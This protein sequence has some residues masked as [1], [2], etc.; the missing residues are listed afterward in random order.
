MPLLV[1]CVKLGRARDDKPKSGLYVR[2]VFGPTYYTRTSGTDGRV[3]F[4]DLPKCL[5]TD[6]PELYVN[7]VKCSGVYWRNRGN[8]TRHARVRVYRTSSPPVEI[9]AAEILRRELRAAPRGKRRR[10]VAA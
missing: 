5:P 2:L 6:E 8:R 9:N 7:G 3:V 4:D 10:S 1:Y